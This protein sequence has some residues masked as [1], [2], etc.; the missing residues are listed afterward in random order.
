M[1]TAAFTSMS[2]GYAPEHRLVLTVLQCAMPADAAGLRCVR[3]PH[4]LHPI[5]TTVSGSR[6][7]PRDRRLH[8]LPPVRAATTPGQAALQLLEPLLLPVRQTGAGQEFAGGQCRRDG[9][10]TVHADDLTRT[11]P[12]GRQRNHGERQMPATDPISGDP[13]RLGSGNGTRQPK[14]YPADFRHVDRGPLPAQLHYPR[15]L[16]T[17]D[18]KAVAQPGLSPGRSSVGAS[19]EVP[20]GLVEVAQGLL[21]NG[22]RPCPQPDERG[23]CLGQLPTLLSEARCRGPIARPHRPL[24]KS[25]VPHIPGMPALLQ[26]RNLLRG[27]RV[28]PESGHT[29]HPISRDRQSPISEGRLSWY[30]P[31]VQRNLRDQSDDAV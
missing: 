4:L 14:P 18:T 31:P 24:L 28:H 19:V 30:I 17:D 11:R 26:Q 3:S 15:R 22:Q 21:L 6:I 27:R 12:G 16:R 2:A 5:L 9:D 8:S 20:A 7:R 23:P 13:V 29:T 10:A 1:F 25:K